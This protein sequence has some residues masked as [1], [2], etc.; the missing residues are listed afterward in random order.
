MDAIADLET[1]SSQPQENSW[2]SSICDSQQIDT[3]YEGL[4]SI[5]EFVND[6]KGQR[7][8]ETTVGSGTFCLV[9]KDMAEYVPAYSAKKEIVEG[10]GEVEVESNFMY[11][12]TDLVSQL[13]TIAQ[14]STNLQMKVNVSVNIYGWL[15]GNHDRMPPS[16]PDSLSEAS[17]SA[18]ATKLF[19]AILDA[20]SFEVRSAKQQENKKKSATIIYMLKFGQLQKA[21]WLQKVM[22]NMVV[23]KGTSE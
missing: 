12:P 20:F 5:E 2:L 14:Q 21:S 19:D 1:E 13:Q 16:D 6:D 22:S 4:Q 23:K 10:V 17:I 3:S 11:V 8:D 18:G 15:Y 9:P 7:F